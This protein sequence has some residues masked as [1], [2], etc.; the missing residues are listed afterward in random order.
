M[1]KQA[2]Q[3]VGRGA[4]NGIIIFAFLNIFSVS[5]K[6]LSRSNWFEFMN[7]LNMEEVSLN[8]DR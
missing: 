7:S 1:W 8:A 3:A 5:L 2:L 6:R 4:L